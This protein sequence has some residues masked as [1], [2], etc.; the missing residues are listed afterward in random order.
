MKKMLIVDDDKPLRELLKFT[1]GLGNYQLLEAENGAQAL[2]I[3]QREFPDIILLDVM[4]TGIDGFEVCHKIKSN[5]ALSKSIVIMVTSRNLDKD[6]E[7]GLD[8]GADYYVTK[9]FSPKAL[10]TITEALLKGVS[11]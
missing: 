1:F 8:S 11:W 7:T 6:K 10:I 3:A 5:P 2:E 4:M 9:P